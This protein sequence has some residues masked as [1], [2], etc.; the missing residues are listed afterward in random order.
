MSRY[1]DV[2]PRCSPILVELH[3]KYTFSEFL[4]AIQITLVELRQKV[5]ALKELATRI[6]KYSQNPSELLKNITP[7]DIN[8]IPELAS[9]SLRNPDDKYLYANIHTLITSE[10]YRN[11]DIWELADGEFAGIFQLW[12]LNYQLEISEFIRKYGQVRV[13]DI[14]N[15]D[16]DGI[17]IVWKNILGKVTGIHHAEIITYIKKNLANLG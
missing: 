17:P 15:M 1:R 10:L 5:D 9:I 2:T 8:L 12:E 16:V 3:A 13:A 11:H 7:D 4:A 14:P 6:S